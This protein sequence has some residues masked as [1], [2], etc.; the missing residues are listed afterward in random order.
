MKISQDGGFYEN[1]V[2]GSFLA[3][4]RQYDAAIDCWNLAYE[5]NNSFLDPL[6]QIAG[7]YAFLGRYEDA[8]KVN[9]KM[10]SV[11]HNEWKVKENW[12][13]VHLSEQINEWKK[14]KVYNKK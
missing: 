10:I 11:I 14:C 9:E 7:C 13:T 6:E 2:V 1:Y 5:L 12:D 3:G 4:K 8:I